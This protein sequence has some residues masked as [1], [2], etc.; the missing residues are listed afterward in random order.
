MALS[1]PFDPSK[2]GEL[3]TVHCYRNSLDFTIIEKVYECWIHRLVKQPNLNSV[4]PR[5]KP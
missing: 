3:K 5:Y 4:T 2:L 1:Q